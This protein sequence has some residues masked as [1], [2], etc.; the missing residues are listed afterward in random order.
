MKTTSIYKAPSHI[1]LIVFS[2]LML[3]TISGCEKIAEK[4]P[5]TTAQEP[6]AAQV[7]ESSNLNT[8]LEAIPVVVPECQGDICPQVDIKR[9][10]SNYPLLDQAVEQ[11]IFNYVKDLMQGFDDNEKEEAENELQFYIDKFIQLADE[12][13]SLGSPVQFS[14]SILPQLF[15][16]NEQVVSVQI[17]AN[18]YVGGAHGSSAQRY[19]NLDLED[20]RLLRLE[21]VIEDGKQEAFNALAYAAFEQWIKETQPDTDL[22]EYQQLWEFNLSENFHLSP[23]GVVLQYGEYEI[24]PYAVGLPQLL[25]PYSKL[26]GILVAKYF[27]TQPTASS[28]AQ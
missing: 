10:K 12:V 8:T 28:T 25:I 1:T 16:T 3:L 17:L 11:Y 18:N 23:Q 6:A 15:T 4:K 27:P 21:M 19:I 7:K 22:T 13:K 14:L 9:F 26:Q 2:A 24:G 20:N 5:L